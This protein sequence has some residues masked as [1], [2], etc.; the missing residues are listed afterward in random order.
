MNTLKSINKEI[1]RKFPNKDIE[2]VRGLGY[3]YFSG[4]DVCWDV[5]LEATSKVNN[6]SMDL[7]LKIAEDA[8]KGDE[9]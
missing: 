1:K 7:W 3:F 8:L 4:E 9:S 6:Y 5:S 2:L